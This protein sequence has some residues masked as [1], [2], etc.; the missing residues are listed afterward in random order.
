MFDDWDI[1]P[2]Q[3]ARRDLS[4]S[5][6]HA[7]PVG[8]R[9]ALAQGIAPEPGGP[10]PRSSTPHPLQL[11]IEYS[12]FG[13]QQESLRTEAIDVLLAAYRQHPQL[14]M[15]LRSFELA[16]EGGDL[17]TAE[18][19]LEFLPQAIESPSA[20]GGL[21]TL[22]INQIIK[23][24][25]QNRLGRATGV[26]RLTWALEK[27]AP[28]EGNDLDRLLKHSLPMARALG[29]IGSPSQQPLVKE[30]LKK[31]VEILAAHGAVL[32]WDPERPALGAVYVRS[33]IEHCSPELALTVV[34]RTQFSSEAQQ[35]LIGVMVNP[36]AARF[37]S[38]LM[39][40]GLKP[41]PAPASPPPRFGPRF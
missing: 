1:D 2:A 12:P 5:A 21:V 32:P 28:I 14:P 37:R 3:K 31:A 27:G 18:K 19:L 16:F 36:W 25:G 29:E 39:D 26:E 34:Q 10:L 6:L 4:V 41:A 40:T 23:E 9:A 24:K 13:S 33:L 20:G 7:D 15:P 35:A 30:G 8:L 22:A 17:A 11:V 38:L